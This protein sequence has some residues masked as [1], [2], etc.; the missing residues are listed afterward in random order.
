MSCLKGQLISFFT[1]LGYYLWQNSELFQ[2]NKMSIF[3]C[4]YING[5]MLSV[6][7]EN[8]ILAIV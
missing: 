5:F 6:L 2:K 1:K 8:V 4:A 3:K 7:F